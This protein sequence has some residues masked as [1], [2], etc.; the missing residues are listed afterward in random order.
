MK[1]GCSIKKTL[2][3]LNIIND[4][5]NSIKLNLSFIL[6]LIAINHFLQ[7]KMAAKILT[8]FIY[9]SFKPTHAHT[10]TYT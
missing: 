6:K 3:S 2:K 9:T 7:Q 1:I 8:V 5:H 10:Y 4:E